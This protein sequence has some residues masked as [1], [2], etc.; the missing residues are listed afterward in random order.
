LND[1]SLFGPY[2]CRARNSLGVNHAEF[3]LKGFRMII[4]DKP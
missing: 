4:R 3:T 2:V 1:A